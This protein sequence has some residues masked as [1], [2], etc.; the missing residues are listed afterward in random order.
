MIKLYT[1]ADGRISPEEYA[2][3]TYYRKKE[4]T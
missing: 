2:L 4:L 3:R 1:D